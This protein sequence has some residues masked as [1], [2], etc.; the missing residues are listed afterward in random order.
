MLAVRW[1][2]LPRRLW[3]IFHVGESSTRNLDTGISFYLTVECFAAVTV[4]GLYLVI[5][6]SVPGLWRLLTVQIFGSTLHAVP[7]SWKG[8][9]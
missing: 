9:P 5:W 2:R 1:G 6:R 4:Q 8:R 7:Q 3:V